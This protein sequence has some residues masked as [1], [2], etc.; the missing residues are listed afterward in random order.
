MGKCWVKF[1]SKYS[2]ILMCS[3]LSLSSCHTRYGLPYLIWHS[4]AAKKNPRLLSEGLPLV[5]L[6][7]S[8]RYRSKLPE[9]FHAVLGVALWMRDPKRTPCGFDE[10]GELIRSAPHP[11]PAL[12]F[13]LPAQYGLLCCIVPEIDCRKAFHLIWFS[14]CGACDLLPLVYCIARSMSTPCYLHAIPR[15]R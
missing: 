12:Q 6:C 11:L 8:L 9:S 5:G 2:N 13:D 4:I 15:T 3:S 14:V 1:I 10:A 7:G